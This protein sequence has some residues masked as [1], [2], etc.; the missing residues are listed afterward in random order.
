MLQS[1]CYA[2]GD[3]PEQIQETDDFDLDLDELLPHSSVSPQKS[4]D[5]RSFALKDPLPAIFVAYASGSERGR[6]RER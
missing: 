5:L 3:L 2:A 6:E 4:T 1:I